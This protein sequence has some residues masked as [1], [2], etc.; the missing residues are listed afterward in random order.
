MRISVGS[1]VRDAVERG[2]VDACHWRGR[3]VGGQAFPEVVI[4][5]S[6]FLARHRASEAICCPI[7]VNVVPAH[8]RFQGLLRPPLSAGHCVRNRAGATEQIALAPTDLIKSY[9]QLVNLVGVAGLE[10]ELGA[11][12]SAVVVDISDGV[13][14]VA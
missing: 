12:I 4:I 14:S 3:S 5:A 13:G 11:T 6:L 10:Y 2:G 1:N 7:A 9:Q 8:G